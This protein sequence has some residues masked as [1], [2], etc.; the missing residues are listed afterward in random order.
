MLAFTCL[1]QAFTK[2]YIIYYFYEKHYIQLETNSLDYV[3]GY[4]FYHLTLESDQSYHIAL[5]FKKMVLP[6]TL[7]ETHNQELGAIIITFKTRRHYLEDCKYDIFIFTN[8]Y[9][10]GWFI[11]TKNLSFCFV[12]ILNAL[13]I[14]NLIDYFSRNANA[15]ANK[16][17]YLSQKNAILVKILLAKNF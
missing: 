10:L 5:V 4:I 8:H 7:Y 11:D 15:I 14:A 2:A 1:K 12:L 6:V 16:L 13:S 17:F 9:N 3:I